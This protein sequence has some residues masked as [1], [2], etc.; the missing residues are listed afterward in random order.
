MRRDVEHVAILVCDGTLDS[1]LAVA[2]DVLR[3]ANTLLRRRGEPERFVVDVVSARGGRIRTASGLWFEPTSALRRAERASIMIVP[4]LWSESAEDV[5]QALARVDVRALIRVVAAASRRGALVASSCSGAFLLGAAGILDGRDATTTWWLAP[6]LAALHPKVRVDAGRALVVDGNVMTAGAAF[7]QADVSLKVVARFASPTLARECS[8]LLL[9][10]AHPS[11]APY[12]AIEH[13]RSDDRTVRRAESWVRT[14]LQ[15]SF[16]LAE[17]AKGVGTSARTLA[18]RLNAAVGL[19]PIAF[20]QRLR[21]EAAVRLLVTT[22]LS[23]QE[24]GARV[25]YE[26][27]GALRRLI[28][29]ETG[30]S[31]RELRQR[32]K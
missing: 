12:M 9:L 17:L 2:L 20:V 11:Q 23:L 27:P 15:D 18:R 6:H 31:P 25:G 8:N 13:L 1:G 10:D 16:A 5:T 30:A 14:R 22:R 3:T 29:R 28:Q 26:D 4:G 7:A 32:P 24:I 21:V 19:S